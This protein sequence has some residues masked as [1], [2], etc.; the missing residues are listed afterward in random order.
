MSKTGIVNQT[1]YEN[2]TV[3]DQ[4]SNLISGLVDGDFTKNLF[5]N[6]KNLSAISVTIS[7]M[8]SG[9][10][11]AEY[12]PNNIGNWFLIIYHDTY[13]PWGKA[14]ET[15]V[16]NNSIDNIDTKVVSLS[17]DIGELDTKVVSLSG[18]IGELDT[19]TTR[20]LGL[21]QENYYV[22]N[23]TYNSIG[24]MISSRIRVYSNSSAVGTNN[25]VIATYNV[26][27]DYDQQGRMTEYKVVKQ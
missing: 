14:G 16:F 26:T 4:S 12:I 23:A 7:E 6:D 3:V 2:F 8:G 19:L 10:Y 17:G 24:C 5:D 9:G 11:R 13:F 22:D 25:D 27:A 1:V 18:D 21:V 15:Q 20:I